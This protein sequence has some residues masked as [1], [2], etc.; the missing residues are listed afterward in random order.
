MTIDLPPGSQQVELQRPAPKRGRLA[1]GRITLSSQFPL[2]LFRA[3]SHVEPLS[4]CLVYPEP[5]AV[6]GLP[7]TTSIDAGTSGDRGQ[8]HDDF[9]SLR[10]YR[11]GDS[12]RHVHWKSVAR[13]QPLQTKQFGGH[14][15]EQLWLGWELLAPLPTEQRLQRLCR[16]VLEAEAATMIYGLKLPGQ[17][18]EPGFG[19]AQQ[20]HALEM[21]A[22]FGESS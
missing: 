1:L 19:A 16:W 2:G 8:G 4:H 18:L 3:W 9:A 11:S 7:P 6:R 17:Q 15:S 22:L 14:H 12:L 10:P 5:A 21:L 20:R 13:G